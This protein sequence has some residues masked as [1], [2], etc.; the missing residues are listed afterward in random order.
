MC[1][2]RTNLKK[3]T[4]S[5][6]NCVFRVQNYRETRKRLVGILKLLWLEAV[7][8]LKRGSLGE[9]HCVFHLKEGSLRG[10]HRVCANHTVKIRVI[11]TFCFSK[12]AFA[13]TRRRDKMR[14]P[15]I[16]R[17]LPRSTHLEQSK[18][19]AG[20][21]RQL[22]AQMMG[23]EWPPLSHA[24]STFVAFQFPLPRNRTCSLFIRAI[25]TKKTSR[26]PITL[27]W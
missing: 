22:L 9:V 7:F 1:P 24:L 25:T 3:T 17:K 10:V 20:V 14:V 5:G 13:R 26:F 6:Q 16:N 18:H 27:Q 15:M 19:D 11:I 23:T 2:K 12:R 8:H 4:A 21:A